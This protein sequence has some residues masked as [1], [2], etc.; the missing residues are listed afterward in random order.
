M[1]T[2]TLA[3]KVDGGVPMTSERPEVGLQR[4]DLRDSASRE[5]EATH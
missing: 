2:V 3:F 5:R 1:A 4:G